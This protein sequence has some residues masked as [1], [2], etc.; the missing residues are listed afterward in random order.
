MI[1]AIVAVVLLAIVI[2][3]VVVDSRARKRAIAAVP[4]E[5]DLATLEVEAVWTMERR[6]YGTNSP[7]LVGVDRVRVTNRRVIFTSKASP[8]LVINLEPAPAGHDAAIPARDGRGFVVEMRR[9]DFT[10]DIDRVTLGVRGDDGRYEIVRVL[11]HLPEAK[12]L[13]DL[14]SASG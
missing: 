13:A 7:Q 10:S 6:S 14:L 4:G 12:R 11:V 1:L 3:A 2:A 9:G 8:R 5:R